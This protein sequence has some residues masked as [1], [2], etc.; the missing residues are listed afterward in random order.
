MML[1]DL[2]LTP[3][4]SR[5]PSQ[6]PPSTSPQSSPPTRQTASP[7]AP[8][9]TDSA[10][11][12]LNRDMQE[13][14]NELT[15]AHSLWGVDAPRQRRLQISA[16]KTKPIAAVYARTPTRDV[17]N[18]CVSNSSQSTADT[19]LCDEVEHLER[20]LTDFSL[21]SLNDL[22]DDT[23]PLLSDNGRT[24][25]P[26]EASN[27]ASLSST[28]SPSTVRLMTPD[29][30]QRWRDKESREHKKVQ[31]HLS[32]SRRRELLPDGPIVDEK[33][34]RQTS[35]EWTPEAQDAYKFLVECGRDLTNTPSPCASP[36]EDQL[37]CATYF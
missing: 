12:S 18:S 31:T 3:P 37:V 16:P 21:S 2:G 26:L 1:R 34:F 5:A 32:S 8:P 24:P 7:S 13:A 10:A 9:L 11:N 22:V 27:N 20:D 17:T 33:S 25:A 28:P 14:F 4:V 29:E 35:S 36:T 19:L 30:L 15:T 6:P 23:R